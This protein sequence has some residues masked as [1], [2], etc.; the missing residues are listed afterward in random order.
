MLKKDRHPQQSSRSKSASKERDSLDVRLL[1]LEKCRSLLP[2]TSE[3]GN[4]KLER[5]RDSLYCLAAV[6]VDGMLERNSGLTDSARL[7]PQLFTPT[8]TASPTA[9]SRSTPRNMS[10]TGRKQ[11]NTSAG[12]P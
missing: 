6:V 7:E 5:L 9:A 12:I 4:T 8:S 10:F 2:P 1:S 11:R 3:I